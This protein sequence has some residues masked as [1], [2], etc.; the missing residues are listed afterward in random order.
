MGKKW[1]HYKAGGR[2]QPVTCVYCGRLVPRIKA[3]TVIKGFRVDP[4]I[5]GID[6][7]RVFASGHKEYACI[8]CA[9]HRG[10]I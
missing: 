5:P 10:L 1:G 8:S 4:K 6:K 3:T 2:S 7:R 9:K